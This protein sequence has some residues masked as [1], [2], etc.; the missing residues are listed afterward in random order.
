MSGSAEERPLWRNADR[1]RFE[2]R[3]NKSSMKSKELTIRGVRRLFRRIDR[4]NHGVITPFEI[5]ETFKK[6]D[7]NLDQVQDILRMMGD[8]AG[9]GAINAEMFERFMLPDGH[10]DPWWRYDG[11]AGKLNSTVGGKAEASKESQEVSRS[12]PIRAD[13]TISTDEDYDA[14][15]GATDE[16]DDEPPL[17]EQRTAKSATTQTSM[18][19]LFGLLG[20]GTPNAGQDHEEKKEEP[21]AP[22]AAAGVGTGVGLGVGAG[23]GA[24]AGAAAAPQPPTGPRGVNWGGRTQDVFGHDE[25][26]AD[27]ED[28]E[29]GEE[30]LAGI[31][32]SGRGRK[33]RSETLER[34]KV[35][36]KERKVKSEYR[37]KPRAVATVFFPMTPGS[38]SYRSHPSANSKDVSKPLYLRARQ[39]QL[40]HSSPLKGLGKRVS[41]LL[42]LC[43][44][45]ISVD[46]YSSEAI[47]RLIAYAWVEAG[48][49]LWAFVLM[50][51]MLAVVNGDDSYHGY[52]RF[53]ASLSL[54][55]LCKAVLAGGIAV[56][57]LNQADLLHK[58]FPSFV[59]VLQFPGVFTR[60]CFTEWQ[61]ERELSFI[62][63]FGMRNPIVL[64]TK[65]TLDRI[66][67]AKLFSFA[68]GV[69]AF[70]IA[71][72]AAED[73]DDS[74]G[75]GVEED[76][77]ITAFTFLFFSEIWALALLLLIRRL[78]WLYWDIHA[79]DDRDDAML[80]GDEFTDLEAGLAS[81]K[82]SYAQK[83][84]K[85]TPR[86]FRSFGTPQSEP[87]RSG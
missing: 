46:Q 87:N 2:L 86:G 62:K 8:S 11:S 43:C 69:Y 49:G 67:I 14:E 54:L 64:V 85:Y 79:E 26:D 45:S 76:L 29:G 60:G 10:Q 13:T 73:V 66:S 19:S 42:P 36:P 74:D 38:R 40:K 34:A 59:H 63:R 20:T 32:Q 75:M 21:A 70:V 77:L 22:R 18:F 25:H 71:V 48:L 82:R 4:G 84:V 15:R 23:A 53:G 30:D 41:R 78:C 50:C 31:A 81:A 37:D 12:S 80:V 57:V 5:Q 28:E 47:K 27:D 9:N 3:R 72:A 7:L 17:A 1:L 24:G 55:L 58:A 83:R 56:H 33:F 52:E 44:M 6:E 61:Q 65:N 51:I 68:L 16:D 35:A 39:A